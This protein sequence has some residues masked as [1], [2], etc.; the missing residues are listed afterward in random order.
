[1]CDRKHVP[2]VMQLLFFLGNVI[3]V[4]GSGLIADALGRAT[5]YCTF[6]SFWIVVGIGNSFVTNM[7]F[8][9]FNR[10]LIG[11]LSLGYRNTVAVYTVELTSGKYR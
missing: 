3:G 11:A 4:I 6:L 9:T 1:M 8:W 10:F 7:Y 5:C 2:R